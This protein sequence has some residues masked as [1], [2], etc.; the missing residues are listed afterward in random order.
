MTARPYYEELIE[1][2][3]IDSR[4]EITLM[5]YKA[6]RDAARKVAWRTSTEDANFLTAQYAYCEANILA[7]VRFFLD[8]LTDP[9]ADWP[10]QD[11]VFELMPPGCDIDQ[12]L[13]R[14][15]IFLATDHAACRREYERY[16]AERDRLEPDRPAFLRQQR[17][18]HG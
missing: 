12:L 10:L 6:C 18:I 3:E 17:V 9:Y 4:H 8:F 5:R 7:H 16:R 15:G 1:R 14:I 13:D 11:Y 2:R